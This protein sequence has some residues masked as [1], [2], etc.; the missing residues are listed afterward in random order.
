MG[1]TRL[2]DIVP[3]SLAGRADRAHA[4]GRLANLDPPLSKRNTQHN[5]KLLCIC[6]PKPMGGIGKPIGIRGLE[7]ACLRRLRV[8]IGRF[9]SPSP[10]LSDSG[11]V[12]CVARVGATFSE[13]SIDG[14]HDRIPSKLCSV[15]G[16]LLPPRRARH[17]VWERCEVY[18][19]CAGRRRSINYQLAAPA[20]STPAGDD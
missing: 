11:R 2:H 19:K 3:P 7:M 12:G 6:H 20:P 14:V 18:G 4:G 16:K 8:A 17:R 9:F 1:P 10:R 13:E 15:A 5:Q